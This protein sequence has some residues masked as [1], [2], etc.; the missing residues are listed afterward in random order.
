MAKATTNSTLTAK[1]QR[2]V[3]EYLIDLNATQA[4]V[5]A[6]YSRS[7]ARQI[8]P[9][10]LSKPVIAAAIAAPAMRSSI[11]ILPLQCVLH[12]KGISSLPIVP[13]N[14]LRL[15]ETECAI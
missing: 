11:M 14:A 6:G 12:Q 3:E 8:G 15:G 7:S 5:R 1:Q 2:F 10:N 13:L 4:A 9:E